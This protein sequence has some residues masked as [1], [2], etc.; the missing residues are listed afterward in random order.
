MPFL[1][2]FTGLAFIVF[3]LI[4]KLLACIL[5]II[6]VCIDDITLYQW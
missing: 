5:Y 2:S 3:D 4:V 6:R 1:F